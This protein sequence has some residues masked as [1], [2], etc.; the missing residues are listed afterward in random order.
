MVSTMIKSP[1]DFW[2]GVMYAGLGAIA[3]WISR[4]YSFGSA[5]RMGPGYFPSVLSGLLMFFGVLALLR[6]LR[7]SGPPFGVFAGKQAVIVLISTAAFGFLLG[8][9]GLIIA[10]VVLILGS[11]AAS[12]KFRFEWKAMAAAIG[13]I[14]FCVLVFVKGLG[15]PIPL[16]GSWFGG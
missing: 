16:L 14:A 8:R 7:K 6:G 4:D 2:T 10:L 15:L 11:A 1:K 3:F 9:A 12:A 5:S 13:L